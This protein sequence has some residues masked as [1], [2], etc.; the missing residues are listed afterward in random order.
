MTP[1][2]IEDPDFLREIID[3]VCGPVWTQALSGVSSLA[4][5]A[6]L[7]VPSSPKLMS[8]ALRSPRSRAAQAKPTPGPMWLPLSAPTLAMRARL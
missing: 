4:P 6:M 7:L 2:P 1:P 3:H 8:T 5:G